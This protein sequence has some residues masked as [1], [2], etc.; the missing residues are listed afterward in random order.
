M[1]RIFLCVL[2]LSLSG[3]LAGTILLLKVVFQKM[4]LLYL[5]AIDCKAGSAASFRSGRRFAYTDTVGGISDS[6]NGE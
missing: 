3:A 5:A 6:G 1:E 2:S 4:E